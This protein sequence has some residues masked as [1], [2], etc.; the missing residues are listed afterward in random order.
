ML[1][2]LAYPG[3]G[4]ESVLSGDVPELEAHRGAVLGR[5]LL[6]REVHAHRRLVLPREEVVHVSDI[7]TS[8]HV[9]TGLTQGLTQQVRYQC[10]I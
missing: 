7:D 6:Q 3:D 9:S 2:P 10:L 1:A 5:Q 4:S 8:N